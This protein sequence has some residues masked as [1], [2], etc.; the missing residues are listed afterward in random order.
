MIKLSSSCLLGDN[1]EF[2]SK[3]IVKKWKSAFLPHLMQIS[4]EMP[5]QDLQML[6]MTP[7]G[8]S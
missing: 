4:I 2:F 8:D 7:Q 6:E 3:S 1:Y 5:S